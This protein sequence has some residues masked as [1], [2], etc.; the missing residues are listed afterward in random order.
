MAT[1]CRHLR[2][3]ERGRHEGPLRPRQPLSRMRF[4]SI[5]RVN[6]L[7]RCDG[8][9]GATHYGEGVDTEGAS[10]SMYLSTSAVGLCTQAGR[11]GDCGWETLTTTLSMARLVARVWGLCSRLC[12]SA[13][14]TSSMWC[15]SHQSGIRKHA[16]ARPL[17]KR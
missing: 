7:S 1:V 16:I 11:A 2:E 10:I 6:E 14:R 15:S 9:I 8:D 12:A 4:P 5:E 17:S 3:D 13:R